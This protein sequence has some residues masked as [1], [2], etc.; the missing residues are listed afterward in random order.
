MR[1]EERTS[2]GADAAAA[3]G[4][5]SLVQGR[6]VQDPGARCEN[7]YCDAD[8][9]FPFCCS[10]LFAVIHDAQSRACS[11]PCPAATFARGRRKSLRVYERQ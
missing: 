9:H 5:K 4:T 2:T 11:A 10:L 7:G 6:V 3:G 1:W 8:F